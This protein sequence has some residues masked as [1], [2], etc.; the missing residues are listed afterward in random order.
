MLCYYLAQE[1]LVL[2]DSHFKCLNTFSYSTMLSR[3]HVDLGSGEY[4]F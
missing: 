3:V 1:A 4:S 2:V